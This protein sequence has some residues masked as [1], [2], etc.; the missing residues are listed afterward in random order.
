MGAPIPHQFLGQPNASALVA[1]WR[2][3]CEDPLI[4]ALPY[5]VE[6]NQR[7]QLLMSPTQTLHSRQQSKIVKLLQKLADARALAGESIAE[8]ALLTADGV[9]VPDVVWASAENLGASTSQLLLS[10]APQVCVE[11]MSPSNSEVEMQEKAALYFA[12]GAQEVWL[13]ATDGAMRFFA[14]SGELAA[15]VLFPDFPA[16]L[17]IG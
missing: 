1:Q 10:T 4:Q 5:K 11:A 12:A 2:A 15:S 6:T 8:C 14:Q 7:G 16:Q 13:C 17:E 9:R 3:L